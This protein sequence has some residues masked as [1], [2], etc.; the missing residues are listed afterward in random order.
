MVIK[1][2][3]PAKFVIEVAD[4]TAVQVAF[5]HVALLQN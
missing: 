4:L 1:K 3:Y 2:S 5:D